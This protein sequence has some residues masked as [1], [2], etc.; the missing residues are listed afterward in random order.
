MRKTEKEY[1]EFK[2]LGQ[3][4]GVPVFEAFLTLEI[5]DKNGKLL[6]KYHQRSHSWTRNAYNLM[7]SQLAGKDIDDST[8]GAGLLSLKRTSGAIIYGDYPATITDS[9]TSVDGT[10]HGY[11][12]DG[13]NDDWGILIGVGTN[14]DSFEDYVLQT[15]IV[16]GTSSGQMSYV[17][18]EAHSISYN[19][20]TK[21]LK[22][23]LVRYFNNNSG[24]T[25]GINEIGLVFK[26]P[27]SRWFL[28][29]RDK[30]GSQI[31]V[32]DTGQLKVTYT[33]ELTYAG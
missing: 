18:S 4:L 30:L 13:S 16:E 7:F 28:N 24:G 2:K 20:G 3:G 21:V 5:F 1:Q 32:P 31:D 9:D 25:I 17:A 27:T 26:G 8:F 6:R 23:D 29:A 12:A 10:S 19:G 22:N 11:R 15:P 33:I 14:A